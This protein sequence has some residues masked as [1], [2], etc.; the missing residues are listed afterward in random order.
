MG[1]DQGLGEKGARAAWGEQGGRLVRCDI[2]P[3]PIPSLFLSRAPHFLMFLPAQICR[4]TQRHIKLKK[5]WA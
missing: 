5:T 4:L 2:H 3:S 1:K